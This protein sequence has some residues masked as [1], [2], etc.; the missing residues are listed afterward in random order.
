MLGQKLRTGNHPRFSKGRQAHR[1]RGVE[2]RILKRREADQAIDERE[3][4][5][6][7]IDVHLI[8]QDHFDSLRHLTDDRL[9]GS[10]PRRRSHPWLLII[11]VEWKAYAHDASYSRRLVNQIGDLDI[12]SCV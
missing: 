3:R 6:A 8:A 7:S 12:G 10:S 5:D 4:Q 1:L 11:V 9:L 2:F